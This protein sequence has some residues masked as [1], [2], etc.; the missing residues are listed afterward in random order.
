MGTKDQDDTNV[1]TNKFISLAPNICES[2]VQI[3]LRV[4]LPPPRFGGDPSNIPKIL[5]AAKTRT[6]S[7]RKSM[8]I[9]SL[10][11]KIFAASF[12]YINT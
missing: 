6:K 10:R 12:F 7:T 1:W 4:T 11:S 9:I 2:S 5:F 3:L 8:L